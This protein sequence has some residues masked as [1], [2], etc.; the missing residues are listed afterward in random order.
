MPLVHSENNQ[1]PC[2]LRKVIFLSFQQVFQEIAF[3][4]SGFIDC[5]TEKGY[6]VVIL[7]SDDG[8]R[9][10]LGSYFAGSLNVKIERI[11]H[12][13]NSQSVI[14]RKVSRIIF[15]QRE[16]YFSPLVR[17]RMYRFKRWKRL[18]YPALARIVP[19]RMLL[20][21]Y[22]ILQN[23]LMSFPE[24][25][26]LFHK[27]NPALV[28]LSDAGILP[29][30]SC[31]FKLAKKFGV[32]VISAEAS[33]D[34]AEVASV[35]PLLDTACVWGE[36]MKKELMQYHRYPDKNIAVTGLIRTDIYWRK[37]FIMAKEEI[38]KSC[39]LDCRK[40]L[41]TIATTPQRP[42]FF[43]TLAR[44]I[45]DA[46]QE[47]RIPMPVQVYLRPTPYQKKE[48]YAEFRNNLS[49]YVEEEPLSF[50]SRKVVSK[51]AMAR[52]V[53]LMRSTDIFI[54]VLSTMTLDACMLDIPVINVAYE[55]VKDI[56]GDI[57]KRNY[58]QGIIATGGT[59]L[60][61]NSQELL[62][63]LNTYLKDRDSQKAGRQK[64]VEQFCHKSDGKA[65]QRVLAVAQR[66]LMPGMLSNR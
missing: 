19:E 56:Y 21:L 53:S 59:S 12:H 61:R 58:A 44:T 32:P 10:K 27:Y 38:F 26:R 47:G 66:L 62:L 60:V 37:E 22:G 20:Y 48:M 13:Q 55:E 65:A 57:F 43:I 15:W 25:D 14:L 17:E 39:G 46:C 63:V 49:V 50:D 1:H 7:V 30:S 6:L 11:P 28:I 42:G 34:H 16:R 8:L 33:I 36:Y 2:Y 24:C 18:I 4:Q 64:I 45:L 35:L 23:K 54:N 5:L 9:Q 31:L 40:K 51:E 41:I 52:L 3:I 29:L